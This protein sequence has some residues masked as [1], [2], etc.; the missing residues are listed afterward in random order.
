MADKNIEIEAKFLEIDEKAL[1][2]KLRALG[3][4]DLGERHLPA[5]I[6]YD[7]QEKWKKN[8]KRFVRIRQEE[9]GIYMCY[10]N[11]SDKT[12]LGTTEIQFKIDDLEK[13]RAFLENVG[14]KLVRE[15]DKK[16]HA[17]RLGQVAVDI[18]TWPKVPPLVE[19]E[20]PSEKAVKDTAKIL[21]FDW[22]DAVFGNSMLM[23]EKYY[24]IPVR[25]LKHYTFG[26]VN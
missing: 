10:K 17:F 16:R 9:D 15:Q 12:L 23:I 3:A 20:G 11:G 21:G 2:K 26:R 24:K 22:K 25:K 8:G 7:A 5:L 13:G 1:V 19:I 4:Q 18:D 14:L 6:F